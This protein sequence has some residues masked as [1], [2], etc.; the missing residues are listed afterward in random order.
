MAA[1]LGATVAASAVGGC[2]TRGGD[3]RRVIPPAP[4]AVVVVDHLERTRGRLANFLAGI[5]GAS[6]FLELAEARLGVS[7][8]DEEGLRQAGLDP[9]GSAAA[10]ATDEALVLSVSVA[11]PDAF[12][13]RVRQQALVAGAREIAQPRGDPAVYEAR[14]APGVGG[15][16]PALDLAWG[17]T[18]DGVGLVVIATR[19]RRG[20]EAPA[21]TA[22][23]PGSEAPHGANDPRALWTRLAQ[24]DG[25]F[26]RSAVA[27]A[28]QGEAGDGGLWF[29]GVPE[30]FPIALPQSLPGPVAGALG[31]RE[32]KLASWRGH[33]ELGDSRAGLRLEAR[34]RPDSARVP[35]DWLSPPEPGPGFATLFPRTTTLL[36]RA[37]VNL[38]PLHAI[39]RLLRD[40]MFPDALPPALGLPSPSLHD[41]VD[42]ATGDVALGIM[43]LDP[44]ATVNH[45]LTQLRGGRWR[46]ADALQV[47]H[48]AVA[49]GVRDV[50]AAQQLLEALVEAARRDGWTA[51]AIRPSGPEPAALRGYTLRRKGH[52]HALL[53][54][55]H[56]LTWITGRGEVARFLAAARGDALTFASLGADELGEGAGAAQAPRSNAQ[57]PAS[58]L[59]AALSDPGVTVGV[60]ASFTRLTRELA[61]KGGPPYFLK[62][63]NDLYAVAATAR[64]GADRLSLALDLVL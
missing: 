3:A 21:R 29:T 24:G 27:Q 8:V 60:A 19:P 14:V 51:A 42:L 12:L 4:R 55:D 62:M 54:R 50:P 53:L 47:V 52:V 34:L 13:A 10:F 46:L 1:T 36:T 41:L 56:V 48:V 40:R 17:V 18:D 25:A 22:S 5:E 30:T 45:L 9:E 63:L 58:A 16:S 28:A 2:G 33:V 31:G 11:N 6:G 43:G 20:A 44:E 32:V 57:A 26:A 38:A 23:S 49:L 61:A 59:R 39:P 35:A 37:R 7:L 64:V 15:H